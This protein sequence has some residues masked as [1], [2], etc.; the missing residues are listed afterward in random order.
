[1]NFRPLKELVQIKICA[2]LEKSDQLFVR[3]NGDSGDAKQTRIVKIIAKGE[4]CRDT[5]QVGDNCL[6]VDGQQLESPETGLTLCF[7]MDILG[8]LNG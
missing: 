2:D 4:S 1:M 5:Y 3:D 7:D 6:I 8:V